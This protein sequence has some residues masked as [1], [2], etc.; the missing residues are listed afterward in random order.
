M[1]LPPLL[2]TSDLWWALPALLFSGVTQALA[3]APVNAWWA[4]PFLF[5]PALAVL[6]RLHGARALLAGWLLGASANA[7]IFS[8]LVPTAGDFGGLPLPAAV[9]LL[10][11]YS[12]AVGGYCAAFAVGVRPVMAA[13]GRWWPA[14][15]ALWFTACEYLNPQLFPYYQGVTW[16]KQTGVFLL[17]S[18]TGVSVFTFGFLLTSGTVVAAWRRDR[19]WVRGSA[20]VVGLLVLAA[21]W[22]RVQQGRIDAAPA[23]PFTAALIQPNQTFERL[24]ELRKQ[25]PGAYGRDFLEVSAEA[26]QAHPGID[27][28]VWGEGAIRGHPGR[29]RHAELRAFLAEHDADLW[30]GSIN[31]RQVG[32]RRPKFT[33]GFVVHPDGTWPAPQDKLVLL[34][35]GEFVPLAGVLPFLRS[36]QGPQFYERGRDLRVFDGPGGPFSYLICY[37][38]IRPR[39]VR[40]AVAGGAGLLVNGSYEGWYGDGACQHQFLMLTAVQAASVG[41]PMLRAG[42]TG[43]SAVIDAAGRIREQTALFERTALVATVSCQAAPGPYARWGDWFPWLAIVLGFRFYGRGVAILRGVGRA[44]WG[45]AAFV[46]AAPLAWAI[47]PFDLPWLDVATWVFAAYVVWI[48]PWR[49][50]R[51]RR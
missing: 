26:A 23:H 46:A 19:A 20:L 9:L 8:W 51:A 34:P 44:G 11:V 2:R 41:L 50:R 43:I 22:S 42:T 4:H 29:E 1:A 10:V 5:V 17:V 3:S 16:F 6:T 48:R 40:R 39:L 15:L 33:S 24:A 21:V 45:V 18:L 12:L 36:I 14:A 32:E 35:F 49:P 47:N 38:A 7:A 37:E 28:F 31:R 25:G 13:S 30:T 27:V